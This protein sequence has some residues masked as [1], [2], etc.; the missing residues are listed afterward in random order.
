MAGMDTRELVREVRRATRAKQ[1]AEEAFAQARMREAEA[2]RVAMEAEPPPVAE[3]M[4]VTGL[5]RARLYQMKAGRRTL[6]K[7]S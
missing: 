2:V 7:D 4:L 3:L 5:S 6:A 1:R